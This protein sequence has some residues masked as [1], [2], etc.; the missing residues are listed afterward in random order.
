MVG[1]YVSIVHPSRVFD[2]G[3][4]GENKNTERRKKEQQEGTGE[5]E[6]Q[7]GTALFES[8]TTP[9]DSILSLGSS[10]FLCAYHDSMS[11]DSIEVDWIGLDWIGAM[12]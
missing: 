11:W 6:I 10:F 4:V 9:Y 12:D 1:L 3:W 5:Q 7:V 8:N 2:I